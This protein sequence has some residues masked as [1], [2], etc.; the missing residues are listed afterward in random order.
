LI[1]RSVELSKHLGEPR[2]VVGAMYDP[3]VTGSALT[4]SDRVTLSECVAAMH[5]ELGTFQ[6]GAKALQGSDS[7][8]LSAAV[9]FS[10]ASAVRDWQFCNP[11]QTIK[12]GGSF[13][14]AGDAQVSFVYCLRAHEL[15]SVQVSVPLTNRAG[16]A[17][18]ARFDQRLT[19]IIASASPKSA[20]RSRPDA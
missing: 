15:R 1:Q 5:E 4:G 13:S 10:A 17:M 3:T 7:S 2:E 19:D 12:L 20:P 16:L 11:S 18:L 6:Y 9:G 14:K 8:E